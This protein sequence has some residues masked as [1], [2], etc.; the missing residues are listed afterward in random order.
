MI[1]VS[2]L[3]GAIS[4]WQLE[5][6]REIAGKPMEK[7]EII[8]TVNGMDLKMG[9][10]CIRFKWFDW[11]DGR[12]NY[13]RNEFFIFPSDKD[14]MV[15]ALSQSSMEY[16]IVWIDGYNG[17]NVYM[18]RSEDHQTNIDADVIDAFIGYASQPCE[19]EIPL[20]C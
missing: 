20:D 8:E 10:L 17:Y 1:Y 7:S 6:H 3:I 12:Q 2:D 15:E 13:R 4:S 9:N 14:R 5:K 16:N 19:D 11:D 18:D